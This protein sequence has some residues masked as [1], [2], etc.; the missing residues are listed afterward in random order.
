MKL[1]EL[2]TPTGIFTEGMVEPNVLLSVRNIVERG[3]ATNTFE[4][5]VMARLLQMLKHGTFYKEANPLEVNMS[6]SKDVLDTLRNLSDQDMTGVAKIVYDLLLI[7]DRDA[8]RD[9]INPDQDFSAWIK[10]AT[11]REANQ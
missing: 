8:Y 7:K 2:T 1:I 4:Y 11:S 5:I 10:L 3:K 9:L 6:T